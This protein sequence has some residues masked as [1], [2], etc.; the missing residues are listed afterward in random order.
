MLREHQGVKA[1][2]TDEFAEIV[3][4]RK[5]GSD[6]TVTVDY[7]TKELDSTDQT[8]TPGVDYEATKGT[9]VFGGGETQKTI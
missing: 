1:S 5:N 4:L 6:G 2:A 7:E 9:L 8:A 3:I